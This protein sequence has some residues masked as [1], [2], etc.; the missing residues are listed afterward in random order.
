MTHLSELSSKSR[1]AF[2]DALAGKGSEVP[3][4]FVRDSKKYI[5]YSG[6]TFEK[7]L[8]YTDTG[9]KPTIVPEVNGGSN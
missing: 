8:I 7:G 6:T 2:A 5:S 3:A 1:E 4:D 9:M